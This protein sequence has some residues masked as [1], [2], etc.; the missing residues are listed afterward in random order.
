LPEPPD[1]VEAGAAAGAAVVV[2]VPV[3]VE[4]GAVVDELL[5][6]EP[7]LLDDFELPYRSE[8]QPPPF[9]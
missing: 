4:A 8:Y 1:E 5:A 7:P 6:D 3:D 2:V 9:S